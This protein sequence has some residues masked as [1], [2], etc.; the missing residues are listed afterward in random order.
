MNRRN[1]LRFAAVAVLGLTLLPGT[2]LAQQKP[3]KDQLAGTWTIVS[4]DNVAPDGTKRQL[5]GPN[6]KG[7]L[8]LA[9]NG[10]FAQIMVR[11]DRANFKANNR[12]EGT[13]EENK[14][15]VQGTTATFGTWSADEASKTLVVRIEGSMFPNPVGTEFETLLHG[16]RR[17]TADQQPGARLRWHIGDGLEAK[18]DTRQQV[19]RHSR[20]GSVW[21]RRSLFS[22]AFVYNQGEVGGGPV[23]DPCALAAEGCRVSPGQGPEPSSL[24]S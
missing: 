20:I 5:F 16:H 23:I 7:L 24:I 14:A 10:Q 3:L 13:A 19:T 2:A 1:T 18:H 22:N 8:I 11:A 15:A 17:S 21:V 4:N 9:A 12:L 6:P